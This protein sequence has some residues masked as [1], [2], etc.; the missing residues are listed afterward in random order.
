MVIYTSFRALLIA[1]ALLSAFALKAKELTFGIVP[2]QSA[3][4]LAAKWS[5][6]LTHV[7]EQSG[8]TLRFATAK[9][10]PTFEKRLAS[11]QYDIAYMNP[12]HYVVFH[13][14]AGYSALL[15]QRDKQIR[16]VIVVHKDSTIKNIQGLNQQ[17]L[18]FPAP[19]AF[20]ASIIPRAELQKANVTIK[21]KYVSSHDSV[22]LNVARGFF[23]AGGGVMRT[24]G[25]MPEDIRSQLKVL[26]KTP[27]YTPHAIATNKG[28]TEE[29]R[30]KLANAFIELEQSSEGQA[31]L[32][33]INFKG[34]ELANNENWD[35][36]RSLGIE[37]LANPNY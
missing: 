18:A 27:A 7:S 11:G 6:I 17:T 12:Y 32:K 19:A 24:L 30:A 5:P 23:P 31:L 29:T 26:W 10:I 33:S 25:N 36:V 4:K 9:N 37:S 16:G 28:V 34:L 2:Q 35:D 14:S 8:I 13:E 15:K 20:A 21:P 3:K 22:Y 1:T